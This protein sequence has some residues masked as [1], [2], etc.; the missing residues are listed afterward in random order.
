MALPYAIDDARPTQVGLIALQAD[1][2]IE[3]DFRVLLPQE[4]ECLV[5]RVASGETL[6]LDTLQAME[7]GLTASAALLPRGA[8]CS[9]VG[10]GCTSA[11]ATIGPARVAEM[12]KR[13][14]P[15]EHVTDPLTALISACREA[16][17]R[18]VGLLSPYVASV[19][20]RLV[21]ALDHAGVRVTSFG[22]FDEP[23]EARVVRISRI[24]VREAALHVGRNGV[25]DAVFLSCTN[26]RSLDVID[27]VESELGIPVWSSNQILAW[28]MGRLA[29]FSTRYPAIKPVF[30]PV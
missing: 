5:S 4:V 16:G 9:V 30:D 8:T 15:T 12:I 22:S 19:S 21:E 7:G 23:S 26:L 24:A 13:G 18:R 29:G 20:D 25:C 2:T 11:S 14:V 17:I 6:S 1:E 28:H 27:E 3:R 10:Y